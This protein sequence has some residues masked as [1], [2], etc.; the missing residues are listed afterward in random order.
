MRFHD[1]L[2]P[3]ETFKSGRWCK[4]STTIFFRNFF[5]KIKC[6]TDKGPFKKYVRME[7][8]G[9]DQKANKNERQFE[10]GGVFTVNRTFVQKK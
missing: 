7:G 4:L 1:L 3:A 6:L 10:G 5:R 8:E 9:G 2:K